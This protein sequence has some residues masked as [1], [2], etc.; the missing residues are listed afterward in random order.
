M[1]NKYTYNDIEAYLLNGMSSSAREDF[2]IELLVNKELQQAFQQQ[3]VEHIAME[4]LLENNLRK[5]LKIWQATA[6]NSA[7]EEHEI[8]ATNQLY[9]FKASTV[10]ALLLS[11]G[12]IFLLLFGDNT[13]PQEPLTDSSAPKQSSPIKSKPQIQV[14]Q[15]S[16]SDNYSPIA[17]RPI[18]E[19]NSLIELADRYNVPLV[20][21]KIS[22][23]SS[24]YPNQLNDA[25]K[26]LEE[27][28]YDLAITKLNTILNKE[29]NNLSIQYL[30]G[31]SYYKQRKFVRAIKYLQVVSI[32]NFSDQ[33]QAQWFLSLS[34]LGLLQRQST[35]SVLSQ[36]TLNKEHAYYDKGIELLEN[37]E[38][39]RLLSNPIPIIAK[40]HKKDYQGKINQWKKHLRVTFFS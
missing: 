5:K 30:L 14:I 31:L 15:I 10:F 3:R 20:I 40:D 9:A 37:V 28:K 38:N 23:Y 2:E 16:A 1:K 13:N 19:S 36:I 34:H 39:I 12:L 29:P 33:E 4:M 22:T 35:I 25:K 11:I 27:K 26:D 8:E 7:E 21:D 32:N 17:S 18:D 24:A 6:A